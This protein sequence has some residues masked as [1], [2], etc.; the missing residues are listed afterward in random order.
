MSSGD[1]KL[2]WSAW[3]ST[4][5]STSIV[6]IGEPL[7]DPGQ[8]PRVILK[9]LT[10]RDDGR[11]VKFFET[12]VTALRKLAQNPR[13][14]PYVPQLI[15]SI[16]RSWTLVLAPVAARLHVSAVTVGFLHELW[17][18]VKE[19]TEMNLV[20]L[21]LRGRNIMMVSAPAILI[22]PDRA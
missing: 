5:G 4:S 16:P 21:D 22:A 12:E 18:Y 11:H 8:N 17:T 10:V 2:Q 14:R 7:V 20:D 3:E 13:L 9:E 15:T 1:E 6:R 19:L